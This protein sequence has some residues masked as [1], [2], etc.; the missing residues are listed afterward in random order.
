MLAG[1]KII[2]GVCGGIAAYKSAMLIRLLVKSGAEVR[3]IMTPSAHQF[4]TPLTLSAL[5]KN[6]VLTN[7]E[8]QETG[9]WNNHVQFGLWADA[10]IIAPATANTIAKIAHGYC[11]NLLLAT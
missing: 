6:P 9:E 7:F 3:V 8:Q 11:D 2:L 4:I 1:R 10:M 5:S